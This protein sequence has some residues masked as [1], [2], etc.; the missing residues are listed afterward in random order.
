MLH[1]SPYRYQRMDQ[2]HCAMEY[3]AHQM[4]STI[5]SQIHVHFTQH[6]VRNNENRISYIDIRAVTGDTDTPC[7]DIQID[8][9]GCRVSINNKTII[10]SKTIGDM[11]VKYISNGWKVFVQTVNIHML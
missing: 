7:A 5:L 6:P 8:L 11:R 10:A 9:I 4:I 2:K 3:L 1:N